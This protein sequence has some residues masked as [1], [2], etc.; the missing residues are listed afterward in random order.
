MIQYYKDNNY[1]YI[2][3]ENSTVAFN[4]NEKN[5][6]NKYQE[7]LSEGNEVIELPINNIVEEV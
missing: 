1:I 7:W 3:D 4:E 6:W 2:Y 5:L